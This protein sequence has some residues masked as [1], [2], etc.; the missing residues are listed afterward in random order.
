MTTLHVYILLTISSSVNNTP[1][2]GTG[3]FFL[4]GLRFVAKQKSVNSTPPKGTGDRKS[5]R[6]TYS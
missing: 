2:K 4:V 6:S 1:P 5:W 3:D